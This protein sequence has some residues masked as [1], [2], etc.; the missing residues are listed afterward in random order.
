MFFYIFQFFVNVLDF[1]NTYFPL[2]LW[3]RQKT[4]HDFDRTKHESRCT[5]DHRNIILKQINK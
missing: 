2:G 5:V 4:K 1:L 3:H